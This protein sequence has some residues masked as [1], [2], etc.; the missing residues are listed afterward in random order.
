MKIQSAVPHKIS[1][2]IDHL[3]LARE[4]SIAESESLP[5]VMQDA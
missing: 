1:D 5:E 3:L 2:R 4:V